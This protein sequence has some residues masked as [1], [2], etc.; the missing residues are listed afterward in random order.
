MNGSEPAF[1]F[2]RTYSQ[3]GNNGAIE[4]IE[5]EGTPGISTRLYVATK[6]ASGAV[7]ADVC[8]NIADQIREAAPELNEEGVA[9][10]TNFQLARMS[11]RLA[12][13]LIAAC[14]EGC[15]AL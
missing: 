12:D 11:A 9:D 3:H 2:P 13:A 1:P 7:S 10:A 5:T 6:I 14:K 4:G 8:R 15:N